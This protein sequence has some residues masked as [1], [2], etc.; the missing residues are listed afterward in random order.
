MIHPDLTNHARIRSA[1]RAIRP[2]DLELLLQFGIPVPDGLLA[3]DKVFEDLERQI[4]QTLER[5]R[6]L[7]GKRV[8][9]AENSVVTVYHANQRKRRNLLRYA[10]ETEL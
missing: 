8:V 7:R 5:L 4:R 6:R 3:T 2:A 9:L 10:E 1:Q